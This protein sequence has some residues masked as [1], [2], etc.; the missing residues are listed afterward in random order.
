[1]YI[2]YLFVNSVLGLSILVIFY[3]RERTFVYCMPIY[4]I[5]LK[6]FEQFITCKCHSFEYNFKIGSAAY[7]KFSK[8]TSMFWHRFTW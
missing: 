7:V 6:L 5:F 3:E 1:M 2:H 8:L 4:T